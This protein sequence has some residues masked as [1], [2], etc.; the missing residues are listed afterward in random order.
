MKKKISLTFDSMWVLSKKD[1]EKL[2]VEM[3]AEVVKAELQARVLYASPTDCEFV[4]A[5]EGKPDD[6]LRRMICEM[7]KTLFSLKDLNVIVECA[8]SDYK[9]KEEKSDSAED[10]LVL[11]D[12]DPYNLEADF[13]VEG[14]LKKIH[15]L[16]G[17][18]EFKALAE[19]YVKV[20]PGLLK[21]KTVETL[22]HQAYLFAINDGDGL[23]TYLELFAQLLSNLNLFD[24]KPNAP[25][26]EV[27]LRLPKTRDVSS[28]FEQV[29][30]YLSHSSR[31]GGI[32][33]SIDISEWM[34]KLGEKEFRDFLAELDDK[35]GECIIVFRVPFL[36][37]KTL[38]GL[39]RTLADVL[40]V[41][42]VSF[43]PFDRDEL[44][45]CAK[46]KLEEYGFTIQEDAL[47]V[48]HARIIEEKND[49]RFYGINTLNNVIREMIYKK[50]LDNAL[51]GIDDCIIKKDEILSLSASY[52]EQMKTGEEL[53]GEL[54]GVEAIRSKIDEII[55]QIEACSKY[56]KLGSPCI[57]MRFVGNPGTGKTTVAR[58]VGKILKEKGIL[59]NGF[60]FEYSGRDFCGEF[61]GSTAPKTAAI[62][63]DAYGSV[64]FIDEAYSLYRN[65]RSDSPDYGRE[66]IDTLLAEMENHRSD[67]VIIMAGYPEEMAVLMRSN[68]GLESRMPYVIEFPNY[69]RGQLYQIYMAMVNKN[70]TFTEGFDTAAK[71][72]FDNLPDELIGSK[73][74]SNA[75][76]VRNLYERTWGKAFMRAQLNKVDPT[77]LTKQDFLAASC[78]KEFGKM[79][80]KP[81]RT[82][83]FV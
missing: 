26:A 83:G 66:A 20:A 16:V 71:A 81:N 82:L 52:D 54:V 70:F 75:R 72:F 80:K 13:T 63:R 57:H 50:Q 74:F 4:I 69:T 35:M 68:P 37:K 41:R 60:F 46:N 3:L 44:T 32:L 45:L 9:P 14:T 30:R 49:G 24:F 64:L 7:I 15:A 53:L 31:R 73:E 56:P 28:P 58:A 19:E 65:Q 10:L 12:S 79:M 59:R 34:T 40:M 6:V 8:V 55:C 25:V 22:T 36:E 78:E 76:F 62:C 48:F 43:V 2:P 47:N 23:S 77:V 42:D 17:A 21:H 39:K 5:S 67:L 1:D 33:L 38:N 18:E 61:I 11:P 27:K 51:R 29:Y